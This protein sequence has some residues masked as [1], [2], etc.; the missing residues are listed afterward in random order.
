MS[1][2]PTRPALSAEV[3]LKILAMS[4]WRPQSIA[5]DLGVDVAQVQAV[6]DRAKKKGGRR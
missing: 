5:F 1:D 6:L 2:A 4:T 3:Q